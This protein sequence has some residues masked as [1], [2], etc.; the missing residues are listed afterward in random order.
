M[1]RLT[2]VT[3]LL[4]VPPLGIR[5]AVL[6]L[7]AGRVDVAAVLRKVSRTVLVLTMAE[8]VLLT[9]PGSSAAVI[10]GGSGYFSSSVFL[11]A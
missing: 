7:D 10:V 4:R 9:M 6:S 11:S 2:K 5:I 8:S 3:A 1:N